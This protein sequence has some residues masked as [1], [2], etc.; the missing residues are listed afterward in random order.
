MRR[1]DRNTGIRSFVGSKPLQA[2]K[3][4]GISLAL[5]LGVAGFFRIVSADA[6]I[7]HPALADGQFLAL[8]FIPL[9]SL[10]LICIVVCET[11]VSSY[12]VLRADR[13]IREQLAARPGYAILRGAEA[14]VAV[15]GFGI[16]LLALPVL[17]ADS[18]PAPAG[19]GLML[20][21]AIVGLGI[22]FVSLVRTLL[23]LSYHADAA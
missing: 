6:F 13:S 7:D 23:E 8:L 19:V 9:V 22:L 11:L 17:F 3:L 20:G 15:V 18:T 1:Q 4:G 12:R 5:L 2:S 21:L 10:V 16:I 14:A